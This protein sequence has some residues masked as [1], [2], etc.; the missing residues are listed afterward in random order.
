MESKEQ[1]YFLTYMTDYFYNFKLAQVDCYYCVQDA[2]V[3]GGFWPFHCIGAYVLYDVIKGTGSSVVIVAIIYRSFVTC[4]FVVIGLLGFDSAVVFYERVLSDIDDSRTR[5]HI[6]VDTFC[7]F[8]FL[9]VSPEI[10]VITGDDM[11][12]NVLFLIS[13]SLNT[14]IPLITIILFSLCC[15]S[16][17]DCFMRLEKDILQTSPRSASFTVRR[18]RRDHVDVVD[19]VRD[20]SNVFGLRLLLYV[21]M[22]QLILLE[23]AD[24]LVNNIA[25]NNFGLGCVV[26]ICSS[27]GYL[28]ALWYISYSPWKTCGKVSL[29]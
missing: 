21:L 14:T 23:K 19:R 5:A 10:V 9:A 24:Y 6:N 16:V 28:T 20:V 7:T 2:T 13:A 15:D 25:A 11:L 1:R 26:V 18:L 29:Q 4:Y 22:L 12:E 27:L 8:L 3:H 17:E